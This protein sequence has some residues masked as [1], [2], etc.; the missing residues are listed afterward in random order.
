M[1]V[2]YRPSVEIACEHCGLVRRVAQSTIETGRGKF[3]SRACKNTAWRSREPAPALSDDGLTA[4]IPL[5]DM[6]GAVVAHTLID[7]GD[8]ALVNQWR[9]SLTRGYAKRVG[10]SDGKPQLIYMHRLILGLGAD[11]DTEVDHISRVKI[12]NRRSNLRTVT[13]ADNMQN[14]PGREGA[15]S[16]RG[17]YR[18]SGKWAAGLSVNGKSIH[19][20]SFDSEEEAAEIARSARARLMPYA[21]D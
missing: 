20:G 10:W 14:V 9:W 13:H 15:S 18:L 7:T 17:V 12:D 2:Q 19:L 5:R 4:F 16:H 6:D 3:C 21:T 8:V 1:P 11:D